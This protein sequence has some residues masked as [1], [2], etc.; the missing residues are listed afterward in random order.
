[1]WSFNPDDCLIEV[2]S[3]AGLTVYRIYINVAWQLNLMLKIEINNIKR[4]GNKC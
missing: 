4:T 2:T 3:W 1:M